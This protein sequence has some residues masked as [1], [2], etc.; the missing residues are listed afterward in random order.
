MNGKNENS[1]DNVN[2]N[3]EILDQL[4]MMGYDKNDAI[5]ALKQRENSTLNQALDYLNS[6]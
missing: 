6:Q 1:N 2:V 3:K 5:R 4:V